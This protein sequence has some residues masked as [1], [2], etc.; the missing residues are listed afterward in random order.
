MATI[1]STV[2]VWRMVE[3]DSLPLRRCVAA[4]RVELGEP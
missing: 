2:L 1:E 4:L 3:A